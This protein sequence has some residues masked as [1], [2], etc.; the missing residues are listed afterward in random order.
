M[1]PCVAAEYA[2]ISSRIYCTAIEARRS[3]DNFPMY[4]SAQTAAEVRARPR[5]DVG[6][7]RQLE[8][9]AVT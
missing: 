5:P 7:Q 9:I 3:S 2:P 6:D 8:R 1:S 4:G